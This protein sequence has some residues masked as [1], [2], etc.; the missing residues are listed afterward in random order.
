MNVSIKNCIGKDSS[1]LFESTFGIKKIMFLM[2]EE[3]QMRA[4]MINNSF[5]IGALGKT[6]TQLD[7]RIYIGLILGL[8]KFI[9]L[10]L[11]ARISN[12]G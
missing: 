5:F 2:R 11:Y 9:E 6:R 7:A 8:S 12:I 10:V 3:I 4:G 1:A